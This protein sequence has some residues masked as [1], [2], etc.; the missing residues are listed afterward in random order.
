MSHQHAGT[1]DGP[2]GWH[3]RGY[4]PHFDAGEVPQSITFRLAESIPATLLRRWRCELQLATATRRTVLDDERMRIEGYLNR[5]V[6]PTW[7]S[8]PQI[9]GLVED[10]FLFFDGTRYRLHAWVV[11]PNHVHVVVTPLTGL[12]VSGIVSSWKSFTAKQANALLGRRGEFWQADYFD[13]FIRDE[14]H[15]AAAIH[16]AEENPV[17]AGLCARSEDWEFSS[18][19]HRQEPLTS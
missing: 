10:A 19:R 9:A 18:A 14:R 15:F 4:L 13:R 17:V 16:Y 12:S 3:S 8:D 7:L 11:M 2:R 6:G 5:G 1:G